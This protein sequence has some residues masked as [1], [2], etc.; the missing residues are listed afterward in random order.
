MKK[1]KN[2][3]AYKLWIVLTVKLYKY[4]SKPFSCDIIYIFVPCYPV[5]QSS[6]H[7]WQVTCHPRKHLRADHN[8]QLRL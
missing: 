4:V 8:N 7:K 2:V 1:K 3:A 5:K 6:H